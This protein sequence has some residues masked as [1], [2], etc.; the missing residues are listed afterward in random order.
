[1]TD[2]DDGD[3]FEDR[4][5]A[6][7]ARLC[8]DIAL[9][10]SSRNTDSKII[11]LHDTEKMA[12]LVTMSHAISS[13]LAE[14]KGCKDL[15][16]IW[17]ELTISFSDVVVG[18]SAELFEPVRQ[19]EGQPGR[20]S[21]FRQVYFSTAAAVYD[22]A[23][24]DEKSE[25]LKGI[26]KALNVKTSQLLNFRKNL[27]RGN[28][29]IKNPWA[30]AKYDDVLIGNIC[31]DTKGNLLKH[32]NGEFIRSPGKPSP[33]SDWLKWFATDNSFHEV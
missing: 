29:Q 15:A 1:M 11:H 2:V 4:T 3:K 8:R 33:A 25:I 23:D 21:L 12:Y 31:V 13:I 32:E 28:S 7:L 9:S 14:E 19:P 20:L 17:Q 16:K 5:V 10:T 30:I 24:A 22:L 26:A 27:T 6:S 18:K